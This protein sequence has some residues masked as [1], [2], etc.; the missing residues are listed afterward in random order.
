MVVSGRDGAV[1][2]AFRVIAGSRVAGEGAA[3]RESSV[4]SCGRPGPS[5]SPEYVSRDWPVREAGGRAP[6]RAAFE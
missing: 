6:A 5:P 3:Q 4:K 2:D 1:W